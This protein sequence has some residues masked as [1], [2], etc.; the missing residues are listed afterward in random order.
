VLLG[1]KKQRDDS[2]ADATIRVAADEIRNERALCA[3]AKEKGV[4][5]MR[6]FALSGGMCLTITLIRCVRDRR[7]RAALTQSYVLLRLR[8]TF[9][10]RKPIKR[11]KF[12]SGQLGLDR[13]HWK[14][15]AK[16]QQLMAHSQC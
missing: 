13:S 15:V 1:E 10:S 4:A 8:Q 12:F 14:V 3:Q 2:S 9:R 6:E 5:H 11:D 16:R 7:M